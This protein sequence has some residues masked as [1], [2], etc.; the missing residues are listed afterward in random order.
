MPG[1]GDH[2]ELEAVDVDHVAV[3]RAV[4]AE[5]VRRVQRAHRRSPSARRTRGHLGVVEVVVGEQHQPTS[6]ACSA[7][8]SRW[9]SSIGPGSMTTDRRAPGSRSTQVLVPSSVIIP[10]FGREH[11]ARR[12]RR[13]CRRPRPRSCPPRRAATQRPQPVR[14]RQRPA[15]RPSGSTAGG[16]HLDGPAVRGLEHLVRARRTAP[17]SS[18]GEVRRRQHRHLAARRPSP[19]RP[20]RQPGHLGRT[21]RTRPACAAPRAASATKNQVR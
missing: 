15:R 4:R 8:A 12:A 19:A 20:R 7:S 18:A 13:R 2:P 14:D 17:T 21:P 1:R 3:A 9:P 6:P 5:A 10:G 16:E 11:A